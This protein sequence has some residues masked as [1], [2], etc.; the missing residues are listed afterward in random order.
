MWWSKKKNL[1]QK[2]KISNLRGGTHFYKNPGEA[3]AD[4]ANNETRRVSGSIG[5]HTKN[6][7]D[8]LNRTRNHIFFDHVSKGKE[9]PPLSFGPIRRHKEDRIRYD[10]HMEPISVERR[11]IQENELKSRD[12]Q[13]ERQRES[14]IHENS[15]F[16]GGGSDW[17]AT[18]YSRGPVNY[19]NNSWFNGKTQFDQFTKTGQYIKNTD[20]PYAAAPISTGAIPDPDCMSGTVGKW[21][22]QFA[23]FVGGKK[24]SSPKKKK[25]SAPKKKKP[26]PKKKKSA[27]KRKKYSIKRIPQKKV[28]KSFFGVKFTYK[29]PNKIKIIKK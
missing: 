27:P 26:V 6:R 25:K 2:K 7:D 19:P 8:K 23:K 28:K 13:I 29:P 21:G 14:S 16:K 24:K 1:A 11:E 15:I 5:I 17:R 22:D 12:L 20:L 10:H 18:A 3:N 9:Q 4:S